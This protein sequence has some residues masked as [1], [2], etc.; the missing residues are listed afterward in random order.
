[1]ENKNISG[2]GAFKFPI[3]LT[4]IMWIIIF[5]PSGTVGFWQGWIFWTGFSLITFF[6]TFYFIKRN[7]EFLARRAKTM[8][9]KSGRDKTG[10]DKTKG[11]K[12]STT[13]AP[14][15]LKIFFIGF[16][17][18]GIDFRFHWSNVPLWLVLLSNIIAFAAYIFIFYVFKVNSY[19]SAA[20][21]VEKEQKV[22][23]TGPYAIIR[24]PMYLGMVIMA[25]FMPL[26]LGSYFSLIPIALIIPITVY[27]LKNEE[28]ILLKELKGYEEYCRKTRFRLIP[29]IW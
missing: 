12:T 21:Q 8:G 29:Y 23:S 11:D 9:D 18:P 7:P 6:I 22:I 2:A 20:I 15:P 4:I 10:R 17:L 3:A 26:A 28:K 24:H 13:K 1:M 14:A 27:R 16:I 19:A 25:L 5:I